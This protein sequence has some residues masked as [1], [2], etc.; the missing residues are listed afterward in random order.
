L[1]DYFHQSYLSAT[2]VAGGFGTFRLGCQDFTGPNPPSFLISSANIVVP[3]NIA[4]VIR[5]KKFS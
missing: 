3:I 2:A 5:R 4:M 1:D